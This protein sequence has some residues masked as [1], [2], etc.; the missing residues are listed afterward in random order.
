LY[1]GEYSY[2]WMPAQNLGNPYAKETGGSVV[3][4]QQF[5]VYVRDTLSG[6]SG[7]DSVMIYNRTVYADILVTQPYACVGDSMGFASQYTGWDWSY[8]WD[9]GD[10]SFGDSSSISHV[11][12]ERGFY[13][14]VLVVDNGDCADT[15]QHL[16]EVSKLELVLTGP[17]RVEPGEMIA[18][19]ARS[20]QSF[21]IKSW[22]P[23]HLI[24]DQ[25]S[26]WQQFVPDTTRSYVVVGVSDEGCV[27][28]AMH[29]VIVNPRVM[30]PS[31]FSPNG[32]GKNDLFRVITW[33]E[34]SIIR[35]FRVFD[36]WGKLVYGAVGSA[37]NL[38]WD[39]MIDGV[40]AEVGVYHYL[41]ELES[42]GVTQHFRG[43]VTLVR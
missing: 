40:P 41:I 27:D 2:S 3:D 21:Q 20:D 26:A 24:N 39:G 31:A 18:L 9:F 16:Q 11:Y 33:G 19:E 14:V 37:A 32:D 6:C 13:P 29:T 7:V 23:D 5:K 15:A 22:K 12:R 4:S 30:I 34:P 10:G 17:E 28:S 8:R 38:G 25:T 1:V 42:V 36:R 35:V 43:D